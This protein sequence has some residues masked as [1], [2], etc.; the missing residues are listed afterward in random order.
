MINQADEQYLS[1]VKE[2]LDNGIRKKDRTGV[3]TVSI[4]GAQ[5]KYDLR[6]GF[7]L[8]TTKRVSFNGILHE[9]LWFLKGDT[10]IKYLVDNNVHIWDEWPFQDY[11]IAN[12]LVE[13]FPMYSE[14]WLLEKKSFIDQILNDADFAAKWG[15]LGPVYGKQWRRWSGSDGKIYD[16]IQM[17]M[18]QIKKNPDSRRI[19][20]SAWNVSDVATHTKTAPPLCHT[21][22]Q[23]YVADGR[24]DLQLYQRSADTAL[25]VP[26]NVASYS[27]LLMMMA[28]ECGLTPGIFVHTTG[29]T[30]LY[31]NHLDGI[32]EQLNREAFAAPVLKIVRKPF[33]DLKFEDFILENYQYQ[34][35]IK[36]PIAV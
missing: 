35:A 9:L 18:D 28:Q 24:L 23:F 5:R 17:A 30:H 13:K 19:L 11:L 14:E 34:P 20:V 2:I 31:L 32:R 7:P 15:D 25:G 29:D 22:F 26:F 27:I 3:G 4:F 10:N 6:K 1:L 21:M 36:F 8:L 12:D 33:W 16:Q